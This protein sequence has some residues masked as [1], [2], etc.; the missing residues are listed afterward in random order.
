MTAILEAF[1]ED[2]RG[3]SHL[4]A[5]ARAP[6]CRS[7][8][9]RASCPRSC[10]SD[11]SSATASVI[12]LG[13]RLFELGQLAEQPRELRAAALPVMADLRNRTGETV[14]LA[15][16]DGREMVCIAIMRGR[17]RRDARPSRIGGRVPVHA[18]ALGKAVLAYSD[19]GRG[20]RRRSLRASRPWTPQTII[21]PER[22]LRQLADIRRDRPRGGGAESSSTGICRRREPRLLAVGRAG[23]GDL[24]VGTRGRLRLGPLRAVRSG[25]L[26]RA[27]ATT[28]ARGASRRPDARLSGVSRGAG[29]P[30][31]SP[32]PCRR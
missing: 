1:D 3:P 17:G 6:T 9:S 30:S 22:L 29:D 4:R 5:R 15:I 13:L 16:R 7:P 11:T 18:T 25:P 24:G 19:A 20:R 21:D 23:R 10:G 32:R 31:S 8:R 14:Y 27:H 2:D 26:R 12:H 28:R